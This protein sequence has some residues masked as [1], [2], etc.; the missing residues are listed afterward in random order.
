MGVLL[1]ST[2]KYK[3]FV[4]PLINQIDKYFLPEYKKTIFVFSDE[5]MCD[6]DAISTIVHIPIPAYKWPY[7]TLLRYMLFDDNKELLKRCSHLTYMDVDMAIVAKVGDDILVDE[8]LVVVRHPGFYIS[9]GWGNGDNENPRESTSYMP[10]ENRKHYYCGGVQ[11]GTAEAYLQLSK[12]LA[13]NIKEDEANG[14]MAI[15]HDETHYNKYVNENV[16]N[17]PIKELIPSYCMVEQPHLQQLWGIDTLP[18]IIIALSK[19]HKTIRE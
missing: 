11:S 1:I 4:Q 18:K 19:D 16:N 13:R 3:Q 14:V 12:T 2:G 15:Y 7:P 9:D 5:Y 6:L 17:V 8:G 10:P